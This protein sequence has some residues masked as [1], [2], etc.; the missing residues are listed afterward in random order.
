MIKPISGS[1]FEF[2]HFFDVEGKYWNAECAR[3]SG[4]DWRIKISEIAQIGITQLVLMNVACHNKAYYDTGIF[5]KFPLGCEDPVEAVLG[6]ADEFG[7]SF[8]VGLGYFTPANS[9]LWMIN[10]PADVKRRLQAMNEIA[11]RYGHHKSFTGWYWPH[12]ASIW[13]R[14]KEGFLQYVNTCSAEARKLT[15]GKRILIAPYGTRTVV[16][17]DE[18]VRQLEQ[19]DVDVVAYQDEVGVEKTRIEELPA[20]YEKL[21]NVHDRVPQ[22]KLYADV[23]IFRFEGLVYRSALIPAPFERVRRQLEI[24]SDYADAIFVYQYQGM[25]NKPDSLAFA[26]HPESPALYSDYTGWR[27]EGKTAQTCNE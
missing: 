19:L 6:A 1:W 15:P 16:P 26:G 3:F 17:D 2:Q 5:P 14:L 12:E 7:M 20:I 21:R 13:S 24:A 27:Q 9:P 22:R 18:Y 25:M 4:A 8:F 23:E 11:E 10:E